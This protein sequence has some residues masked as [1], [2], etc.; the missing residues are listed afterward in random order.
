MDKKS[1]PLA[2]DGVSAIKKQKSFFLWLFCFFMGFVGF[3]NFF[4][5]NW[6]I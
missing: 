5:L 3:L 6:D 1:S 4:G 2:V